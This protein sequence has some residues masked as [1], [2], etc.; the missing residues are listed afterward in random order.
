MSDSDSTCSVDTFALQW[1]FNFE[2]FHYMSNVYIKEFTA[3]CIQTGDYITYYIKSPLG[4]L[5]S[6]S[7]IEAS[8]YATQSLRHGFDWM[9]GDMHIG[10]FH[11]L[12]AQV[13]PNDNVEIFCFSRKVFKYFDFDYKKP[14]TYSNMRM[15]RNIAPSNIA[16]PCCSKNHSESHCA[17]K[18]LFQM[19]Y[20]M[21]PAL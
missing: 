2:S 17:Q 7:T 3:Y 8:T 12:L 13:I 14:Y 15:I 1:I 9:E 16:T 4:I 6:A 20:A 5:A 18:R 19:L 11:L 10:E 21:Q